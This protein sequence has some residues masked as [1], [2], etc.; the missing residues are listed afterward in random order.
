M[1]LK[2]VLKGPERL[3]GAQIEKTLEDGSLVVGRSPAAGWMLP[4]PDKVVSKAHCRIDKD[5]SGF[6][7]TDTS[8]NGVHVN[9]EPVGFGLPRSLADGD[10]LK[11]GDAVVLVHIESGVA[12]TAAGPVPVAAPIASDGPFGLPDDSPAAAPPTDLHAK[13]AQAPSE[14]I[15]DDWWRSDAGP[16]ELP[17]SNP[18]DIFPQNGQDDILRTTQQKDSLPSHVG[19][20]AFLVNS[21]AGIDLTALARA[22]DAAGSVL[23]KEEW[24]RFHGRLRDLLAGDGDLRE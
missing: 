15:L 11:L 4:D 22:V 3:M 20:V 12:K 5:F 9:D 19:D 6:V 13:P 8:T 14:K 24:Q 18:G 7:L 2:L 23:P 16:D 10:V 1:R 17:M 21:V